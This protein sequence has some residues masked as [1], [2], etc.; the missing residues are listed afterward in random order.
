MSTLSSDPTALVL[1][2]L[3][4]QCLGVFDQWRYSLN[5]SKVITIIKDLNHSHYGVPAVSKVTPYLSIHSTL[6]S[7]LASTFQ[8]TLSPFTWAFDKSFMNFNLITVAFFQDDRKNKANY[9]LPRPCNRQVPWLYQ[10]R[11]SQIRILRKTSVK[12]M[13]SSPIHANCALDGHRIPALSHYCK[14]QWMRTLL[15]LISIK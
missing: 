14:A 8:Y 1:I 5:K 2:F 9:Q 13:M 11:Y 4:I 10:Q 12:K 15:K 7:P 3:P 6:I